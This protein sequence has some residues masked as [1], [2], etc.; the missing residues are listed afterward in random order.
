MNN[1]VW[2]RFKKNIKENN[3]IISGDKVLK[4]II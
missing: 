4:V 1:N 3:L 2:E